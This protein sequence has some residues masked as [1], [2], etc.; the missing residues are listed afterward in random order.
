[1]ART[2]SHIVFLG[3]MA[4][5]TPIMAHAEDEIQLDVDALRSELS[6]TQAPDTFGDTDVLDKDE[7][8]LR[9]KEAA[10]MQKIQSQ[11]NDGATQVVER[12]PSRAV[13][14]P[15]SEVIA[16]ENEKLQSALTIREKEVAS[17]RTKSSSAE[18]KLTQANKTLADLRQ[19]LDDA[20]RR[21]LV[22][23]T[24]VERLSNVLT[25]RNRSALSTFGGSAPALAPAVTESRARLSAPPVTVRP[26]PPQPAADVPV[27][28][29]IVSKAYLRSGPSKDSAPLMSVAKGAR[30][31]V[32]TRRGEWYR[33]ITPQG[34][35]AWVNTEVIAFGATHKDPPTRTF[36][37][38]G[39]SDSLQSAESLRRTD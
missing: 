4:F 38:K 32:E 25:A 19:Q 9:A 37:I 30:L 12:I 34:T 2:R 24:E 6:Q 26:E 21:L 23:E 18:G 36:R 20:K 22:A 33:V 5:I 35:R 39:Y 13:E 7:Q 28:Q 15:A 1:M 17:L 31:V 14:P 3:A 16:R 8:D 10:L 29:V 27:A 11:G